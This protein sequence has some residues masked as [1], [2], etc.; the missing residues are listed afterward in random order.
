MPQL[1]PVLTLLGLLKLLPNSAHNQLKHISQ[2]LNK[3]HYLKGTVDLGL[4]YQKSSDE[5][6]SGFSDSD[7]AGDPDNHH[8]TTGNLFLM[9][10]GA[11]SWI[12]KW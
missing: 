4:Q 2:Q 8:S 1:Q 3:F 5:K 10:G 12:S 9:S 11:V 6:V 7:W